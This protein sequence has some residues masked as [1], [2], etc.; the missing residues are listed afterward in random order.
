VGSS[1]LLAKAAELVRASR[2]NGLAANAALPTLALTRKRRRLLTRID[3]GKSFSSE[4]DL[5]LYP[6]YC[7]LF[8]LRRIHFCNLTSQVRAA[9]RDNRY[10]GHT[11]GLC[12]DKLQVNLVVMNS[13]LAD[14][15]TEFCNANRKTCPLLAVSTVGV[16]EFNQL[17]ADI[18]LRTDLPSY[19]LYRN[20]QLAEQAQDI[21]KAWTDDLVAFAIGNS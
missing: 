17:D 13:T 11:A 9:I 7:T 2:L 3:I 5:N 15:F 10:S 21:R 16:P 20:G 6:K 14:D 1:E 18:D 4:D 12:A 19:T 8:G